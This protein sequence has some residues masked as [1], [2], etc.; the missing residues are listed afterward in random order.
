MSRYVSPMTRAREIV[1]ESKSA[2]TSRQVLNHAMR[3]VRLASM[4]IVDLERN[5]APVHVFRWIAWAST[6][7][8]QRRR[9]DLAIYLRRSIHRPRNGWLQERHYYAALTE[10]DKARCEMRKRGSIMPSFDEIPLDAYR[11]AIEGAKKRPRS[12]EP[13]TETQ[14]TESEVAA[15]SDPSVSE[16]EIEEEE[17]PVSTRQ[18]RGRDHV[19]RLLSDVVRAALAAQ[20]VEAADVANDAISRLCGRREVVG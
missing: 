17:E 12:S 4:V 9:T 2:A 15:E 18:L 8:D 7:T 16:D 14:P 6:V 10:W 11:A 20:D 3:I 19:L 1:R 13:E 5:E